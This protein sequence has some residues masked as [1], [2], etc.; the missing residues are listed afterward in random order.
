MPKPDGVKNFAVH[1]L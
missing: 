1:F